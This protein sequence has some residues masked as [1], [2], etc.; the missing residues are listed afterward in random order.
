MDDM[1]T[2]KVPWE[3]LDT[4][5]PE[6]HDKYWQLTLRLPQDRARSMAGA[7]ARNR[8]DR[9]RCAPRPADRRRS[10]ASGRASHRS[11]DC[12]WLDRIDAVDRSLAARHRQA[13]AGRGG[14]AGSR[15]R[16]RRRLLDMIG[17]IKDA[18]GGFTIPPAQNHP[19]F[20]MHALL[21]RFG[22]CPPRRDEPRAASAARSR[23]ADVRSHAP[24]GFDRALAR[25]AEHPGGFA[26]RS[27]A[28][29]KNSP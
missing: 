14:A 24:V 27:P 28:A 29:C 5:V 9:A 10:R 22:I 25:A 18:A 4:L 23:R 17:G 16:S 3:A 12:R 11:G 2:R 21:G 7:P 6:A 1:Q 8:Q 19:Q 20:A 26:T 15:H 13:A